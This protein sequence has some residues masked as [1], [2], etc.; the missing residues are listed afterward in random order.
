MRVEMTG[1]Q[2]T[3]NG[4]TEMRAPNFKSRSKITAQFFEKPFKDKAA[5]LGVSV[6]WIDIGTWQ[7]PSDLILEKHKDAWNLARENAKKRAEV[8][9][10]GKLYE[11]KEVINLI[12]DVVISNYEKG[13]TARKPMPKEVEAI[14]ALNPEFSRQLLRQENNKKDATS[15]ALEILKSFRKELRAA[16]DHIKNEESSSE[17]KQIEIA[18]IDKALFDISHLTDHWINRA[19]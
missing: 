2:S 14:I 6:E 3:A 11:M 18:K 19:P 7:H 4:K 10:S 1:Q 5:K 17:E 15:I 8:E 9:R 16:R 12:N 13:S